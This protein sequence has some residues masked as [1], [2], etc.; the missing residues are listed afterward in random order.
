MSKPDRLPKKGGA[1]EAMKKLKE[2]RKKEPSDKLVQIIEEVTN[3][4]PN[5]K[6]TGIAAK[7]VEL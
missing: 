3:Q 5:K 6:D 1:V 2:M 4:N 7:E